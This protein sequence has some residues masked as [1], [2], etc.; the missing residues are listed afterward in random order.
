MK[1]VR[2]NFGHLKQVIVQRF[3]SRPVST[4]AQVALLPLAAGGPVYLLSAA[5]VI[6]MIE[7]AWL[8]FKNQYDPSYLAKGIVVGLIAGVVP[9]KFA[10]FALL[11]K[12]VM[13][14]A[15]TQAVEDCASNFVALEKIA[16]PFTLQTDLRYKDVGHFWH[17]TDYVVPNYRVVISPD[18]K[19]VQLA[20][21]AKVMASS[22]SD[23]AGTW[24]D[25]TL[26]QKPTITVACAATLHDPSTRLM[27]ATP[28]DFQ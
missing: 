20:G 22:A 18:S 16:V 12:D 8:A 27:R 17:I 4:S 6:G 25:V 1:L 9:G 10:G 23:T 14:D 3:K 15:R 5:V 19:Q 7:G 2:K 24:Q 28:L 26:P 21:S 13:R 11:N